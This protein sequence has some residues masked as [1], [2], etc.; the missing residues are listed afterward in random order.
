M[1][2]ITG[3]GNP[4]L[5]YKRTRHN[6]GFLFLDY[7][8][9]RIDST[10]KYVKGGCFYF[11]SVSLF[12]KK[13]ILL[14]PDTYMNLSGDAVLSAIKYFN[15]SK[16]D[17]IICYDDLALP[18]GTIRIRQ[19]GSDGGHNGLKNIIDCIGNDFL[20]IR[21]GIKTDILNNINTADYVL[22]QFNERE[23]DLYIDAFEKGY[24]ALKCVIADNSVEAAMQNFNKK[25][26]EVCLREH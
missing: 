16:S 15:V 26:Q 14:K 17:F 18:A 19:R 10:E 7:I 6:L 9:K 1:Y 11:K 5:R 23:L 22:S 21:F 8:C 12:G 4:G 25:T 2:I 13:I 3:L 24:D 20:R